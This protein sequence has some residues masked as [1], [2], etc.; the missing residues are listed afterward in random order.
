M[1]AGSDYFL[2]DLAG[3]AP[4]LPAALAAL[5][6]GPR[7][8][9]AGA[10]GHRPPRACLAGPAA[11]G[12]RGLRRGAAGGRGGLLGRAPISRGR[13]E[14]VSRSATR[15]AV[16]RIGAGSR[17]HGHGRAGSPAGTGFGDLDRGR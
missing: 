9:A 3:G 5:G 1:V 7:F 8:R 11:L 6:L 12:G 17:R 14:G 15:S 16:N 13:G 2:R 4:E 10:V